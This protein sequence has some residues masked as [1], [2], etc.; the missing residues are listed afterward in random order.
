MQYTE[1][2]LSKINV[3]SETLNLQ[4]RDYQGNATKWLG[5]NEKEDIQ[6]MIDFLN[7]R[8]NEKED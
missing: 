5:M 8:L 6:A 2:E 7:N 1:K 4:V 3:H